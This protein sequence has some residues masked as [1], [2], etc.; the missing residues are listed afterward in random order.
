MQRNHRHPGYLI[1]AVVCFV[2][3]ALLFGR[4]T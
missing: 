3:A 4:L 2:L 1:A